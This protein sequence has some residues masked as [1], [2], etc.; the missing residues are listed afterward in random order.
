MP[1]HRV[2]RHLLLALASAT[3]AAA[4]QQLFTPAELATYDGRDAG[5]PLLIAFNHT[6]FDVSTGAEFYG[7]GTTY[8]SM[9]GHEI[10]RAVAEYKLEPKL[11]HADLTGISDQQLSSMRK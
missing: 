10:A 8:H 6:V 1:V 7:P 9:A 3:S 11:Y 2:K 4:E 5:K